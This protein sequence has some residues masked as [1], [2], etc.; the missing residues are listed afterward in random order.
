MYTYTIDDFTNISL[1]VDNVFLSPETI[2]LINELSELVGA[3]DYIKTPKFPK[4][5][6]KK[7][8]YEVL[9]NEDWEIIRKFKATEMQERNG[10]DKIIDLIIQYLN[11]VT[12]NTYDDYK[13]KIME[14][15][16]LLIDNDA[17][18]TDLYKIGNAIFKIASSNKFNS[19]IYAILYKDLL[20]K[21]EFMYKIFET[22][23]QLIIET[24]QNIHF[25]NPDE[26]YNKYC[27]INKDNDKRKT[28]CLFYTNLMKQ[29]ILT[30]QQIIKLINVIQDN[31]MNAIKKP[32]SKELV[33]EYAELLYIIVVNSYLFINDLEETDAIMKEISN[34]SSLTCK[35][36][37][38]ISNKVIF[39]HMDILDE[40]EEHMN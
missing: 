20:N 24:L 31:M 2:N 10:I 21:Y 27:E 12:A 39:K 9:S 7:K 1:N 3:D 32:D 33:E 5:Q 23:Y 37:P 18:E 34:I 35:S 26:D 29:K 36:F 19:E 15:I 30:K 17:S 14:Q 40:L 6:I 13:I 25:G 16:T 4:K 8:T 28:L 22:N 11:K 38:S